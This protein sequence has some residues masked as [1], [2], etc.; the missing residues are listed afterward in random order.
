[1]TPTTIAKGVKAMSQ[2]AALEQLVERVEHLEETVTSLQSDLSALRN[3]AG[4][5]GQ[6]TSIRFADKQ[7]LRQA[8]NELLTALGV[9]G[10]PVGASELRTMM[11]QS[12]LERD[13]LSR[14]L[15][16]ARDE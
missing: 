16:E 3:G 6:T 12:G 7:K 15:I 14:S 5:N 11:K 13:E 1:M 4:K 9:T 10:E 8:M 2:T